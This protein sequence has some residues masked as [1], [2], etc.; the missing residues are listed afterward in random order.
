MPRRRTNPALV[1]SAPSLL[2]PPA[3]LN[4]QK[5]TDVAEATLL[6]GAQLVAYWNNLEPVVKNLLA[7]VQQHTAAATTA[8]LNPQQATNLL[9]TVANVVDKMA[10]AGGAVLKASEGQAR[11]HVL[12]RGGP[13]QRPDAKRLSERQL[14]AVVIEAAKRIQKE[15]GRCPICAAES[16][17]LDV[18]NAR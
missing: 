2:A 3:D 12:L 13:P 14:A 9:A 18:E 7:I 8:T 1:P 10:K 15:T 16:P 4:G 17:V 5:V 6:A 11:L